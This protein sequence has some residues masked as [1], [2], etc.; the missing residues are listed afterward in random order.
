MKL[1]KRAVKLNDALASLAIEE[2]ERSNLDVASRLTT[3]RNTLNADPALLE[4]LAKL[5]SKAYGKES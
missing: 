2:L 4:R 1:S 3:V 5:L